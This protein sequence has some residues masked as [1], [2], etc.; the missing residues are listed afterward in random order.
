VGDS[1]TPRRQSST[2]WFQ[3]GVV[4]KWLRKTTGLSATELAWERVRRAGRVNA[5]HARWYWPPL[6]PFPSG[7]LTP[8]RVFHTLTQS[9]ARMRRYNMIAT[10]A[11]RP[12][13][14]EEDT[15]GGLRDRRGRE[16]S[17]NKRGLRTGRMG[18]PGIGPAGQAQ[19]H[20]DR[21]HQRGRGRKAGG[22]HLR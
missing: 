16:R 2:D 3:S 17:R 5:Q 13:D 12:D 20:Q 18:C 19:A 14:N 4:A 11:G 6:P 15:L 21:H 7:L 10:Q 8:R 22:G 1:K 9:C